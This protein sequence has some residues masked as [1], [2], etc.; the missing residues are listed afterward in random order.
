MKLDSLAQWIDASTSTTYGESI[1]SGDH[2]WVPPYALM[3]KHH[4]TLVNVQT[5]GGKSLWTARSSDTQ[6]TDMESISLI[7]MKDIA[8]GE[9]FFLSIED[10]LV[11]VLPALFEIPTLEQYQDTDEVIKIERLSYKLTSRVSTKNINKQRLKDIGQGLRMLQQTVSRYRPVVAN[12]LPITTENLLAYNKNYTTTALQTLSNRT[13]QTLHEDASCISD[14]QPS[15]VI[16]RSITKGERITALP[17]FFQQTSPEQGSDESAKTCHSD[18]EC[19]ADGSSSTAT[20]SCLYLPN[21]LRDD[22]FICPLLNSDI[23]FVATTESSIGVGDNDDD[24]DDSNSNKTDP[25][26]SNTNY[27]AILQWSEWNEAVNIIQKKHL[28]VS[29]DVSTLLEKNFLVL[30]SFP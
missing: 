11:K 29:L 12:L 26:D 22:I 14:L 21:I 16:S 17:L 19:P 5:N 1:S 13:E 15:G 24:D 7:A 8:V 10:H 2:I 4:P 6:Q 20:S 28:D 30:F 3:L 18:G 27:N 9:E 23:E 25:N